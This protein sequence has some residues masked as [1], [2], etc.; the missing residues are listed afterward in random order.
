MGD[1]R[2]KEDDVRM[3]S[4]SIYVTNFPEYTN[5]KELWRVCSQYGNVIDSFIPNRRSKNGKQP[6]VLKGGVQ[7]LSNSYIQA[8]KTGHI[9]HNDVEVSQ[10][11]LVLDESCF[12]NHDFSLSLV[13]KL[14]EFGSL[15]NLKKILEEKGFSDINI[16]YI[17]GFWVMIQF[18]SKAAQD[19]F[20]S[21]V[22][23]NS[24][25]SS[26]QHAS[27][28]FSIDKRVAWIDIEGVPLKV[29]SR[30]T[31]AKISLKWGSLLYEE[32]EDAPY[33]HRKRLCIKTTTNENIFYSFKIVVKGKIFWIR[34]KEVSGWAPNFSD[35]QGDSFESDN[36]SI[37]V[38]S[39]KEH[40]SKIVFKD[41]VSFL[42]NSCNF[43]KLK[44]SGFMLQ[45]IE[46]LI[47]VGKTMG[48]KMEGC[49]NDIEEIVKIQGEQEKLKWSMWTFS[50]S[51][52]VRENSTVSD[53]F[54]AIIGKWLPN[55]KN[56]L[57]ISVY[58][59]QE[60]SE[61]RMLWQYLVHV[62]EGWNGDVVIIG[63]FN[64]VRTVDE[65]FSSIF[66][67]RGAAAFNSFIS[68]GGLVE[69]PSGGYSYT[70]AY[71]FV[72]KMS[73][74]DRFLISEDLMRN[75][76]NISSITLDRFLSGHRPI[77]LR[78]IYLDYGPIP[79]CFFHHWFDILK[80]LKGQIRLW[81]KDK[82]EKAHV[83]KNSVKKK[84]ADIY[85]FLD[86]G[87]ATSDD[88]EDRLNAMNSL[89]N[90][91]R[92]ESFELA[93]KA[94][95]KWSIE[96]DENSKYFH[97]IINKKQNNLAIRGIIVDGE[98]IEDP[99]VVKN[100]FLSHFRNRFW[101]LLEDDVVEAMGFDSVNGSPTS[102]FQFSKGLK[103]GDLLSPFLF[104][105][106]MESL[107]LSFQNVV[108]AG[109]FKG[110][111]LDSS[112]QISH[113]F[114]AEDVVFIGQWCD[115]NLSII[116]RVLDC[117]F[118][119][120][121]LRINL[122]KS[123]LMAI[124]VE[125][126][127][128]D[129]AANTL[130][131][132]I[133]NTPFSYLGVNIGGHMT[134]STPIYY[135]SMFKAPIQVIN[136]LE[137]IRSHFFNG[138]DY[139]VRKMTFVNWKNVPASKEK[140]GLGVSSFYALNC[141]LIFKWV[142]IICTRPNS[143]WS[144]DI[145]AIHGQNGKLDI[146]VA[147]KMA[148][149]SFSSSFRR[150]P[151][152]GSELSQMASLQSH[153]E[154]FILPNMLDRWVWSLSGD[155]VFYG[156]SARILIDDKTV[157]MVGSKTQWCKFVPLKINIHSWRVK[158]NNL[159]TRLNLSR[160]DLEIG[161]I[162]LR[163]ASNAINARRLPLALLV[164]VL[165]T[166]TV[167]NNS[168]FRTF[169]EKQ[170]LT[171]LNFMEWYRNL[172]IVLSVEDK[173]PYLEQ[174]IPALP[175][176]PAGQA[177]PMDVLAT[178]QAWLKASKEIAGLMLITMDPEI[179]KTLD[180]L[181]AF[182]M[183]KELK[184][185]YIDNMERLSHAMTQNHAVSLILVS[186]R[187]EYDGFVQNYNMHSMGKTVTKLHAMLKLHEQTLP[188]KKAAPALHAIRARRPGALS[189]YVGDGHRAGVEAIREFH[190]CLPSG[191][192]LILHNCHYAPSITK[193][194]V[195]VSPLY[196]DGFVNR[197]ENDN[198]ISVSKNN[199]IYCNAIPRDDIYEIVMSNTKDSSM[200]D[201]SNKRVKPN[202]DSA[203][204]WHCHLGHINKK[205]I[206]KLQHDGLLDSTDI[207]SFEKCVA[208]MSGKMARKHYSHQV[209][210]A[211]D[212]LGLIHTDVCGPFK[213]TSRQGASYFVTFTN[214]FSCY[215][216]VYLLKHKHEV[217]ETFKVFQKEVENQLGK[218]I[219]SLRFDR[220]GEYMSQEFLNHLRGHGII[221]HGT[222]PY[223]P[224]HNGVSERR[225][226]TLLDTVRFMMSQTTLPK[227][228]WDYALESAARILN[229]VP[230]KKVD[231]TP[232]EVWHGQA[233]KLIPKETMGYS[234]YYPPENKVFVAQ[235]AEFFKNDV[236]DQEA[237]GSLEEL[238]SIQEEDTH[239]S[240]DTSLDHEEDDQ[241]IN[242]PQSDINPI[243]RSTR[244]RRAPDQMCLYFDNEEHE[245][246]DLGEPANYKAAL[247]DLESDKWLNAM[248]VEMQSMKDNEVWE[249]VDLPPDGKTVGHKRLFKKKIDMD[250]AVHTHKARMVAKG[251]TQ[252]SR[253]DYE[254]T[255]SPV[256]D[257]RTIRI[258]IAI[259]AFY[260]YEIWQMDVKTA[261]LNRFLNKEVYM[262]QPEA[263]RQWIKR[264][265]D[266][267]KKFR[268]SQNRDEPCVYVKASGSYVTFRILYVDDILIMGNN[269]PMLQNV[270]SY[271]GRCFA[272]KDLGEDAYIRGIKIYRDR[273]KRL[274]G[275][276]QSAY[277]EKIIKRFYMENSKHGTIPMQEKLK[278]SISQGSST[279]AEIRRMQN[280]PYAL[281]VG[282]IM[283]VVR[284]TRPDVAFA[285]NITSQFQQNPCD[286]HWTAVK[287]ILKY[288]YN[289]K[290]M[291][292]VYGGDTK[293]ELRVSCYTD[294][295]YLTDADDMKS[296]TGYVF[297]SHPQNIR[298]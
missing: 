147:E 123:S 44:T 273:S 241:E 142:Y 256:A 282:S 117:F 228:F 119:A 254:E 60:L 127:K 78:E 146:S 121:G 272:M 171:V 148:H 65:R 114:Y 265:D 220:G 178:H 276:C 261:F 242:E 175:V 92:M 169:F 68:T 286:A 131:C 37:H 13:S 235:N 145:M 172:W 26:T 230:T 128:V 120:S 238:E 221:A 211:K 185:F 7:R 181:G 156:S 284:C 56:F 210:W 267:I 9:S 141:D 188:Q 270:K 207:K 100:E 105:L 173:L 82:K 133:L 55:D 214:D 278:F 245:L 280:I 159:P 67:A 19:N 48:Y 58:A 23:V 34:V 46:D 176:P 246:G 30:N 196:K 192:V 115:S 32:D 240:I 126:N 189:L 16:R 91:E 150:E 104:I 18:Q 86:K 198:S 154:G 177:N 130:G 205:R 77:L 294:A 231:K 140:G 203:L 199:L 29:W 292:L 227:S 180:H 4:T 21:H 215:G 290:D 233:P 174:L 135:M 125:I 69:V 96:G 110:V 298:V 162:N 70:W 249:L 208:C 168:L 27:D 204:L 264:F 43:K 116:M 122:Q 95:I 236:I 53:Y 201:V 248:N 260:N 257:I 202:L 274:I 2:S 161:L 269:I 184:T 186:L 158:L 226:R 81:V 194:I 85:S 247:L 297:V 3:I 88:L 271:L 80:I 11:T 224:Q 103:Q 170:K 45:L 17:G 179:Q 38:T 98:W 243:R 66:N 255:F 6:S 206:E 216:Y 296:Q 108:N 79:F 137:S 47:K 15:P 129:I 157:G 295:G 62:I 268:F 101:S 237:S 59:P 187:K 89:S 40:G 20:N 218:T 138:V 289:T 277:I 28:S 113:L 263:S 149:P 143:L 14:K 90:L 165:M 107:H 155:G 197:F 42:V 84:L 132:R 51:G 97:G 50:T 160:R 244:T 252:T 213:I 75:C 164:F 64:E 190:L 217:F 71:K 225:N 35:S 191:L 63:Y 99:N 293:R 153:L 291:F 52:L 287:N 31:F 253:I 57:I 283:Y 134:R 223:T 239:P 152:F 234:F 258:L 33:F 93:Q 22:G 118:R 232:Y 193:G 112:L 222:P 76:P 195:S 54:I 250:G 167:V 151:R 111:V 73:K 251:F 1:Q 74:L 183:L 49:I 288:L 36:E 259:V 281:A 61:K 102:E 136:K 200:Y 144:K 182:D 279:P 163:V 5:A 166:T 124:A 106:V 94:K 262:E 10:S 139:K 39:E 72:A 212:L 87:E 229:M 275:L 25:F 83:L 219:K 12:H 209:K 266:E 8:F 109:L 41:D 285:Q 24:W